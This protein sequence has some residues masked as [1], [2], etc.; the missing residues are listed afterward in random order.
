M[1][2]FLVSLPDNEG[3]QR[4]VGQARAFVVEVD[5]DTEARELCASQFGADQDWTDASVTSADVTT[6]SASDYLGWR[7]KLTIRN[8]VLGGGE[9]VIH[10]VEYTGVASDTVNLIG[11]ELAALLQGHAALAAIAED[12]GVF[13]DETAVADDATADNVT[14]FPATPV[15][16]VDRY[17]VGDVARFGDLKVDVTTAGIGTYTVVW[18]YWNG[19]A[20]VAL[21]SV[22]GAGADFKTAGVQPV[23]F[24]VPTDWARNTI[25]SQ[26]PF[27]FVRAETQTGTT[28]T[29][30]IGRRIHVGNKTTATY[31]TPT[32]DAAA[33]ADNIGDKSLT[34]E[35]FP[36]G[37]VGEKMPN[38][39]GAI[40]DEGIA[41]A[42][43]DVALDIPTAIPKVIKL[44]R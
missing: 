3:G 31:S 19:T 28:T 21:A 10:R 4:L 7:Y 2:F 43:L 33:I 6:L 13:T 30:P 39:V 27:Y 14:L 15:A 41:G 9:G 44:V 22:A 32:L 8:P 18:E 5:S 40:T 29:T 16:A 24:T 36:A 34:L 26:G 35:V 20:W 38:M 1:A 17:N 37:T 23:T 25:N 11:G 12:G 42:V